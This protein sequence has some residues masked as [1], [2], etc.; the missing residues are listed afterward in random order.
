MRGGKRT[1]IDGPFAE[2]KELLIG[3]YILDAADLDAAL[4][5]AARM[6]DAGL[7]SLEIR[8]VMAF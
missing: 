1:V 2:T 4:D 3:F 8:P 5:W 6:P 7:N